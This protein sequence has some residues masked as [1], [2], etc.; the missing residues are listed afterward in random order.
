LGYSGTE[1]SM[2]VELRMADRGHSGAQL[3]TFGVEEE[4]LLVDPGTARPVAVA[5]SVLSGEGLLP[6]AG[7]ETGMSADTVPVPITSTLALEVKQEQ[8]EVVG[9]PCHT[10]AG[11][12][13]A[14]RAGRAR[15]DAAAR[16]VGARAVAMATA[17]GPLT[18]HL[19]STPRYET[20]LSRFGLIMKEQLTCGYH[21][22]V[23]VNSAE[24]GVAVLDRIR[25]WLPVLLALSSNSPF[26]QGKDTG[27]ASYRYQ[28]WSRWPSAGTYEIFGSAE[29]YR[30]VV[31]SMLG[32][33]VLLDEGMVYFDARLSRHHPTVEI[34]VADV[35]LEA[36][37][38][39]TVAALVRA[40]VE[41]AA[42]EWR[43]GQPPEPVSA[44]ELRLASWRASKS[45]M[46]DDLINPLTSRPCA[47]EA[48]V[49]ALISH[50]GRALQESGD[51]SEVERVLGRILTEGS[52]A[53]RQRSAMERWGSGLAVVTA[54]LEFT[55]SGSPVALPDPA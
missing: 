16:L 35:C 6:G 33:G 19:V 11:V 1:Q 17:V 9:P 36:D 38:A 27:Y 23:A 5:Q 24:E 8:I 15:A 25:V 14:I 7:S 32:T 43:A 18:T 22:H 49:V 13:S 42:R 39:A 28:A 40:L 29:G 41:T 45:G 44:L 54:A 48:A 20:M 31:D 12:S 10:L 55:H 30:Q 52:G 51:L 46:T 37:H 21:V 47:P 2:K 4:L 34:R 50:V 26:W 3:R 53:E